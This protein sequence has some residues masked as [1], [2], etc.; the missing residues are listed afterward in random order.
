MN[1]KVDR[2]F[3]SSIILNIEIYCADIVHEINGNFK[4][5]NLIQHREINIKCTKACRCFGFV[6]LFN[7][8]IS[9]LRLKRP[10]FWQMPK[11]RRKVL[12]V[13]FW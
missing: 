7:K 6:M 12:S 13:S 2:I 1:F 5:A 11:F 10:V 4:E 3:F 9:S 8:N